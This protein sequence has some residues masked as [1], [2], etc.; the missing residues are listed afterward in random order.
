MN[1]MMGVVMMKDTKEE[2]IIKGHKETFRDDGQVHSLD[3]GEG[4]MGV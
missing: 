3:C 1:R 4:F 2:L